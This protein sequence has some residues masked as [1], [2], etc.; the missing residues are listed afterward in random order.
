M[1]MLNRKGKIRNEFGEVLGVYWYEEGQNRYT[2]SLYHGKV[3]HRGFT[4]EGLVR[5]CDSMELFVE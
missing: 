2:I 5:W 3:I 1:D 4:E